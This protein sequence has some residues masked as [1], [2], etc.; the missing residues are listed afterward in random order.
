MP[1][2][3][4]CDICRIRNLDEKCFTWQFK[5]PFLQRRLDYFFISDLLQDLVETADILP[6]V[7]SDHSTLTL[8]LFLLSMN[9]V[10]VR[11]AGSSIIQ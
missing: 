11:P 7:Q 6:S 10:E 3:D 1:E 8:T 5:N 2:N 9:G 4:L